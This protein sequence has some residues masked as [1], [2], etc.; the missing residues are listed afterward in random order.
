MKSKKTFVS[1]IASSLL[2]TLVSCGAEAKPTTSFG[3]FVK[4][5]SDERNCTVSVNDSKIEFYS[6][7]A[8]LKKWEGE[9][10]TS[11]F[12]DQGHLINKNQGVL[13]SLVIRGSVKVIDSTFEDLTRQSVNHV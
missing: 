6:D 5:I 3:K 8:M 2:L 13:C 9:S 10:F 11:Y 4:F 7:K 12:P 1:L